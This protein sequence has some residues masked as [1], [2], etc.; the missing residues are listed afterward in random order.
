MSSTGPATIRA[1][2]VYESMFGCT[3][4]VATAV[5]RGLEHAGAG[6]V[7]KE[8]GSAWSGDLPAFDLLVVGGPTHAFSLSRPATR[9]DAVRQGGRA[10]AE[11]VGLREWIAALPGRT[12]PGGRAVAAFDT[13]VTTLRHVPKAA[14]GRASRLLAHQGFHPVVRPQGFLVTDLRGPL[15]EGEEERAERWGGLVCNAAAPAPAI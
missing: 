3:E 9:R 10:T 13:R 7:L 6:V 14:A 1:L 11:A 15:V 12:D 2:V 8:V 5:A 4:H